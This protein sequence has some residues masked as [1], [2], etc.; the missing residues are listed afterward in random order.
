MS[1]DLTQK[2]QELKDFV[3]Q[4]ETTMFLGDISSLMQF[5]RFDSPTN[6]LKGLSS[7][8]RQL[9]YLAGLNVTS[10]IPAAGLKAKYSDEDLDHMKVLLNGIENGYT[11]FFYPRPA[12]VVDEDWK[13]RRMIAMPTFLGYFNHGLLNYEEQIIERVQEYFTPFNEEIKNHF[14]LEV[15]DFI[16]IYNYIDKLP[17]EFLNQK[18]NKKEG[19]QTWEEFCDEMKEKDLMPMEWQEHLPQHLQDLFDW[20]YDKGKMYRY[21]KQQLVDNFGID[22]A[23][24]FLNTFTSKR[25]KTGFL[26]YTESNIIHS[27][28]IFKVSDDEFQLVE[29]HQLIQAVYNALFEFCTQATFREKFYAVRGKKLEIKIENVFQRF[30]KG[31]A[32]IYKSFFTQDGH[33]Q[34][35]LFL[36][37]GMALIVEAKA[38]KRDEP[39]R[40]PDKAYPLIQ[41]NF[42]ETIQKGY[43]QAYRVKSKFISKEAL[44]IYSDEK[45]K[46]HVIDIRTKNYHSAFSIIVTL[47]RFGQI[48]TDLSSLLEIYD[49]D[50][51]PWSVCIDD[52]EIFLLQLEKLGKNK[53]QLMAFLNLREK[54]H[55]KLIT[56]DELEVCGAFIN[57]KITTKELNSDATVFA[58][59][60][61]L[62]DI[63]DQTYQ[64]KGLGFENEKNLKIKTSG[65]YLPI[66]GI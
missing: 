62:T 8:Q 65:K 16:N 53:S 56:A 26:Y 24:A 30:F 54:L 59:T 17:N 11:E 5:I 21:S 39:R 41:S 63:F 61:D 43:D 66:G 60:P 46:K 55:G 47:E 58:L 22:K 32:F 35:L 29:A 64:T 34:D 19:Q 50:E 51:F 25:E 28:P 42:E 1:I 4:F 14:K 13:M 57:E 12:D 52:L 23:E 31:K 2:S 40:E 33:E 9:L 49:D 48:Q 36:I 3:S 45:L 38:S 15:Q 18:I 6:S 37:D 44:N 10:E 27:R 7:P 20:M